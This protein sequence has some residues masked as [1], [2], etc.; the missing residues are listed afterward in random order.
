[1]APRPEGTAP[2]L[3]YQQERVWFMEQFAPG[4]S[5]YTIPVPMRLTGELDLELLKEA[6]Q[7]LPARHEALRM[8]FPPTPTAARPSTSSPP[9]R[10]RCAS[11][12]RTT[13]PRPRC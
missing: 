1:M 13:R 9:S 5:Q 6:L 7:T 12:P 11:S 3:S 8:R 2:P 4:T 10:C